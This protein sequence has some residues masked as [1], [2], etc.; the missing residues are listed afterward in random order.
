MNDQL[1]VGDEF[2]SFKQRLAANVLA[3]IPTCT[4]FQRRDDVLRF[5]RARHND[6]FDA[7][8]SGENFA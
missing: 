5:L 1:A 2:Q 8:I 4:R 3:H 6:C 7:M